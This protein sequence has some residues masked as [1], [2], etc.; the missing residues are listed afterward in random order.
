MVCEREGD[1]RV[2]ARGGVSVCM[3]GGVCLMEGSRVK[4]G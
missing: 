2:C 3:R 4:W 1:M